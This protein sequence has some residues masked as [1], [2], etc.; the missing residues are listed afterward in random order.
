MKKLKL[1]SHFLNLLYPKTC[2]TC[3]SNLVLHEDCLCLNCLNEIPKSNYHL[4]EDNPVEKRFWGK[5]PIEHATSF[6]IF[7][8]GSPFQKVL[9]HLKYKGNKKI[10]IVLG[11]Y[12]GADICS[13]PAFEEID[14]IVPVPLHPKK[15]K[16]RTYNQSE[17][18]SIGLSE[19]L[20]KP[21]ETG[22]LI[23]EH[24]NS[25]Q[26]KKSV[27]ERHENTEGI[28]RIKETELFNNKHVLLVDDVLTTGATIE[29]CVHALMKT[30]RIKIS[31]F[32]LA[33]AE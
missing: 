14:C 24:D 5:V 26:T 3:D 8:K 17:L 7:Q 6:F 19:I 28:F 33:V 21:I 29:A 20:E 32:T 30:E 23:R 12:A 13:V 2:L 25:T 1:F 22:N 4:I 11:K 27:F 16:Q 15:L 18:I 9:H 31:V 10:G